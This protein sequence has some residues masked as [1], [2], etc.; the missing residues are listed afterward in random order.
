MLVARPSGG[1]LR[2]CRPPSLYFVGPLFKG[3]NKARRT[4]AF[5][6]LLF[7]AKTIFCQPVIAQFSCYLV[8]S[9]LTLACLLQ[10]AMQASVRVTLVLVQVHLFFF[11]A[12]DAFRGAHGSVNRKGYGSPLV[13]M[14]ISVIYMKTIYRSTF[15]CGD[16]RFFCFDFFE[17]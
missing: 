16:V 6:H 14:S 7:A 17:R 3:L 8:P 12:L 5:V 9:D 10:Y 15:C 13:Q 2:S 1:V 4:L 11:L